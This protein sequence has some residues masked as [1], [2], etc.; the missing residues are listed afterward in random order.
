[1][2][3]KKSLAEIASHRQ[4]RLGERINLPDGT[5][6]NATIHLVDELGNILDSIPEALKVLG[7]KIEHFLKVDDLVKKKNIP[8]EKV[9]R[10]KIEVDIDHDKAKQKNNQLVLDVI[11]TVL[12]SDLL[13]P[14]EALNKLAVKKRKSYRKGDK[15]DEVELIQKALIQLGFDLGVA[16]ADGDFGKKTKGS[17]GHFQH[18]YV[19]SHKVHLSYKLE[20]ANG[21][22]DQN[23]ILALD[24]S[25]KE[26]W[27]HNPDKCEVNIDFD[28][29][30]QLEGSKKNGYVPDPENSQSGVTIGSGFDLGARSLADLKSLG[31]SDNLVT[32]F[33]PYLGKKKK[34][35]Q[36][37]LKKHPLSITDDELSSLEE[38][39]KKSETDKVVKAYNNSAS[40][41]KFGCL[42]KEAQTVIASVSYQYGNLST[43]TVNFWNQAINQDWKSMYENLMDFEDKY[44]TRRKKE[45]KLIGKIL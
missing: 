3:T 24:E 45:A 19:P 5:P 41:I 6:V 39:V 43:E 18:V 16:G 22:V 40:K 7:K 13:K 30:K 44:P 38:K 32:K 17:L 23:T 29:I 28:F 21:I 12:K 37:Y 15:G 27:T 9:S 31:L 35:A 20:S 10:V 8:V 1:M 25:L 33:T 26:S 2:P 42:P 36:D 4:C 34:T 14:S 11:P